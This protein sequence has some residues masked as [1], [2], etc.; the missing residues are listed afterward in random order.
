[1]K[2]ISM[3]LGL[4]A[5]IALV[6]SHAAIAQTPVSGVPGATASPYALSGTNISGASSSVNAILTEPVPE[7]GAAYKT[8]NGIY[9]YPSVNLGFGHNDNLLLTRDNTLGSDFINLAPRVMAEMKNKGDRYTALASVDRTTYLN[10]SP[11]NR[12]NSEFKLAGDNYFTTRAR[13]GWSAAYVTNTDDRGTLG[14]PLSDQPD[15]WHATRLD[16]R[17]I[18]G[19]AEAK[20]RAE[21]DLGHD[22]KTYDNN[23]TYTALD[24]FTT[25]SVAGRLYYRLGSRS[26]A[27]V[28][29]RNAQASYDSDLAKASNNTERRYYLGLTWDVTAAT[30]G[31]VKLGR[32]TKDFDLASVNGYSGSSWEATVRWL[33]RT[34]SV[35]E[36]VAN[37]STGES[38]GVGTYD[39]NSTVSANWQ[40]TWTKSL[41]SEAMVTH[42]ERSYGN[43]SRTDSANMYSLTL[44]YAVLRWLKMGVALGR[45]DYS[46]SDPTAEYT[47]NIVMATLK[48]TL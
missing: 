32:M 30:T 1:M 43:S 48:A 19:A 10:S 3:N 46:S 8:E 31:I 26:L 21:V 23:R 15:R 33:P 11:D 6:C 9:F 7:N 35:F 12:T 2:K 42:L 27:L 29:M 40:H 39:L 4:S 28:E 44:D 37:R 20:G 41:K 18:Y 47:R 5:A 16:A 22:A 34:Y 45:T 38:T 24:D 25:T 14:R 17:L 13:A 36:F